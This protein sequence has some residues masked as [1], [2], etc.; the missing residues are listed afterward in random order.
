MTGGMRRPATVALIATGFL[1]LAGCAPQ[2]VATATLGNRPVYGALGERERAMAATAIQNAMERKISYHSRFWSNPR[3]KFS[4][5]VTPLRSYRTKS[6][7]YCRE[8]Q[9]TVLDRMNGRTRAGTATACRDVDGVW[10]V[11][12]P[13]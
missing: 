6:G 8:F 2:S 12:A 4:G 5:W 3:R 13:R 11:V 7:F 10:K 9:E 1:F